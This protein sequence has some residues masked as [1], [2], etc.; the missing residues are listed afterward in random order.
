MVS[1]YRVE[2]KAVLV[3]FY[4]PTWRCAFVLCIIFSASVTE[5][6]SVLYGAGLNY[7]IGNPIRTEITKLNNGAT[8]LRNLITAQ[9][10]EISSLRQQVAEV[11]T[12]RQQVGDLASLRQQVA[13]VASLRQ[14]V[15]EVASLRQQVADVGALRA[16]ITELEGRIPSSA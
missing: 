15:G 10:A 5:M 6:T 12:L 11:A 2:R 8:E 3:K 9:T 4:T 13:E 14:Q 1:V 16:K 7:Q